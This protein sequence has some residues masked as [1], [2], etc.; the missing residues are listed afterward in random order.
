MDDVF[1]LAELDKFIDLYRQY[2]NYCVEGKIKLLKNFQGMIAENTVPH[3]DQAI[4]SLFLLTLWVLNEK[5]CHRNDEECFVC[6]KNFY[7]DFSFKGD[8]KSK[9]AK[10]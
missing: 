7:G 4:I 2:C 5:I 8:W 10:G 9:I 6:T 1:S 3:M